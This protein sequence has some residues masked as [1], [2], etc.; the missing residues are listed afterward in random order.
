MS[1][2]KTFI[3]SS[4]AKWFLA[5][6]SVTGLVW[7][8]YGNYHTKAPRLLYEIQSKAVLFNKT[9]ALSS[10]RLY[11]DSLDVLSQNQ[12][13]SIYTIKVSNRGSQNLISSD[14]DEGAFGIRIVNG[15]ILKEATIGDA[16]N[17][18]LVERYLDL[19]PS[20]STS[21]VEIPR[22]A[23]D[24]GDWYTFSFA[25][26][27]EYGVDPQFLP[28]GKIVGQKEIEILSASTE[29]LPFWEQVFSGGL[30]LNLIRA[31]V[32]LTIV[33]M[34]VTVI[35]SLSMLVWES[36]DKRKRER[37]RNTIASNPEIK[38]F[39]RD[40][41][42]NNE[43]RIIRIAEHYYGLGDKRLTLLYVKA[44]S[45][46][47]D[48][49]NINNDSYDK[50]LSI[51]KDINRLVSSGYLL[52][53]ENASITTPRESK[54]SVRKVIEVMKTNR[55]ESFRNLSLAEIYNGIEFQDLDTEDNSETEV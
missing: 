50:Y 15:E 7:G 41:F 5:I 51:Y 8:F 40:D 23:L 34:M 55:F 4:F 53:D 33:I 37:V 49:T 46:I 16:S 20:I 28:T 31:C 18:H 32:Y 45:F 12:N 14:Y 13:I 10:V 36:Y 11:V 22:I 26:L 38:A 44:K 52:M 1:E 35:L 21:F 2:K 48:T 19:M 29:K 9:E 24:K 17:E 47:F 6:V 39:V 30:F 54:E 42:I 25:V 43:D 3:D 27:H